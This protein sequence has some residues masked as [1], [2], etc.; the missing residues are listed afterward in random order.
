MN[1]QSVPSALESGAV[2]GRWDERFTNVREV[3]IENFDRYGE[4]GAG[5]AVWLDGECVVARPFR[6]DSWIGLPA[7][8]EHRV[9]RQRRRAIS[10]LTGPDEGQRK[11]V[12]ELMTRGTMTRK[13]FSNPRQVAIFNDP[14]LHAAKWPAALSTLS[15]PRSRKPSPIPRRA[16][17]A[18]ERRSPGRRQ[19]GPTRRALSA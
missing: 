3:F 11:F 1:D 17:S 2:H 10:E 19:V 15:T 6:L 8:E 7:S 12:E 4:S 13:V 9:S 18:C 16:G 5:V 14:E